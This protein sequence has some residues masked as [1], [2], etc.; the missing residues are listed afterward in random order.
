MREPRGLLVIVRVV[1]ADEPRRSAGININRDPRTAGKSLLHPRDALRRDLRV[2]LGKVE[3]ERTADPRHEVEAE[4][5]AKSV[6]G[7]GT[8]DIGLRRSE[9]GEL[10]AEPEAERADVPGA[11]AARAQRRDGRR[12]VLDPPG[13]SGD[14]GTEHDIA[15]G[16]VKIA[17]L[18]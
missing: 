15:L 5:N 3:D 13:K 1:G 2:F 11:F 6:I 17:K 7:N 4:I 9:I 10:A 16:G 14:L 18:A 12:D 8:I